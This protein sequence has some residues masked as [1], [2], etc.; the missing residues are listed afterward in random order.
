MQFKQREYEMRIARLQAALAERSIDAMLVDEPEALIYYANKAPSCSLYR[1]LLVPREGPPAMVLR[2]LDAP[3]FQAAS[4]VEDVR[5]FRDWEGPH[6]A[7]AHVIRER[8][9]AGARLGYDGTST[10]FT[11]ADDAALRDALPKAEL[12]PLPLLLWELRLI[13]SPAEI[14]L[15]RRAAGMADDA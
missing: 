4:W 12:V 13:K 8:G 15:L 5:G 7:L 11:V 6:A 2:R 9:L 3:P 10:C 1:A 14:E